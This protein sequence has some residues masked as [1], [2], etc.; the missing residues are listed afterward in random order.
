MC[1]AYIIGVLCLITGIVLV[2]VF[3]TNENA[4]PA[5]LRSLTEISLVLIPAGMF[6]FHAGWRG[7]KERVT[8]QP[9]V[10]EIRQ[11]EHP[12]IFIFQVY[13]FMIMGSIALLTAGAFWA[14]WL[15]KSLV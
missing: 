2:F 7:L 10:G 12:R 15:L 9:W 11:S 3:P 4:N 6:L 13:L 1:I 5:S 14:G 8:Y